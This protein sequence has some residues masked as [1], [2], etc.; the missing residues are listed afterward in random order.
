MSAIICLYQLYRPS[1]AIIKLCSTVLHPYLIIPSCSAMGSRQFEQLLQRPCVLTMVCEYLPHSMNKNKLSTF[2]RLRAASRS[3]VRP[4]WS[5]MFDRIG[6]LH[7]HRLKEVRR[8]AHKIM[9]SGF[10]F[11]LLGCGGRPARYIGLEMDPQT[12]IPIGMTRQYWERRIRNK[13]A[14][15]WTAKRK[16]ML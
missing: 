9:E 16:L 10:M 8:A 1:I 12:G 2:L 5:Q 7:R 14:F 11:Q 3:T 4:I 15:G 6:L 13:L